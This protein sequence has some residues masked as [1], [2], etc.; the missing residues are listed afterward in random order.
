MRAKTINEYGNDYLPS[1]AANDPR[2]PYN[3][4]DID[5]N[6]EIEDGELVL[7]TSYGDETMYFD[8]MDVDNLLSSVS[9]IRLRDGETFELQHVSNNG[10]FCTVSTDKGDIDVMYSDL[11]DLY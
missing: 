7:H 9:K 1:G 2:A 6:A 3:Q 8:P 11:E 5:Y 10:D 4:K